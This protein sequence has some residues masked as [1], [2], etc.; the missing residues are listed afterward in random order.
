MIGKHFFKVSRNSIVSVITCTVLQLHYML[1]MGK[2]LKMFL[3]RAN[4]YSTEIVNP[5][6]TGN[7]RLVCDWKLLRT[8]G[9]TIQVLPSNNNVEISSYSFRLF[10]HFFYILYHLSLCFFIKYM[11]VCCF[12]W[13]NKF[14]SAFASASEKNVSSQ[15]KKTLMKSK[16]FIS[17]FVCICQHFLCLNIYSI[18]IL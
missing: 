9:I 16:D 17:R 7:N 12:Y 13:F 5:L 10:L 8:K 14:P 15:Y 3:H 11:F 2:L 6:E 18:S 4:I 1:A